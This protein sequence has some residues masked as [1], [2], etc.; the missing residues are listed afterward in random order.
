MKCPYLWSLAAS[1]KTEKPTT[2]RADSP[3]IGILVV[4]RSLPVIAEKQM[5]TVAVH[6]R[7]RT[8]KFEKAN[9]FKN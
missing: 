7:T 9:P 4:V 1:T 2:D 8:L 6:Q 5:K 3:A